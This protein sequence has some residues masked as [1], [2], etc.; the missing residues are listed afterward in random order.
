MDKALAR[1]ARL[2]L[3]PVFGSMV[4][5]VAPAATARGVSLVAFTND[6]K[7]ARDGIFVFGLTPEQQ[8][9]RVARHAFANGISRFAALVPENVY[10]NAVVEALFA[11]AREIGG[12]VDRVE[13]FPADALDLTEPVRRLATAPGQGPAGRPFDGLL[14]AA[15]GAQLRAIGPLISYFDLDTAGV[16]LLGTQLWEDPAILGEPNLVG[17][18]FAAP[19]RQARAAFEQ[20]YKRAYGETPP[21]IAALAF[22]AVALAAALAKDGD[23]SPQALTQP[24]GFIGVNGLFRFT[25]NG[26]AERGLAV[27]GV[28]PGGFSLI[29]DAPASLGPPTF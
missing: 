14:I 21:A 29:E 5:A 15:G 16:K 7:V 1:G 3:G 11:T 26:N 10:G 6:R 22:D 17:G 8:V 28:E 19:P 2:V 13:F 24:D 25:A 27:F 9:D 12:E 18:W 23:F 20:R 4:P